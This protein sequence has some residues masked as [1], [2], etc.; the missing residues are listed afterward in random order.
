ML[1]FILNAEDVM[2]YRPNG[3]CSSHVFSKNGNRFLS[4]STRRLC[5]RLHPIG[6]REHLKAVTAQHL[7]GGGGHSHNRNGR[8]QE[9]G[10]R[11]S[12]QTDADST[13]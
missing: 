1:S 6:R 9:S 4:A 13:L 2:P 5:W 7:N 11:P 10:V 3:P 12:L 8:R